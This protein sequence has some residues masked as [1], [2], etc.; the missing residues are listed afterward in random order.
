[1]RLFRCTVFFYCLLCCLYYVRGED[2]RPNVILVMADDMGWGDTGYNGHPRIKTPNLD[3]MAE[4]GFCLNRFYA[5]GPVC[6]PTR[7]SC[8]T[9][10]NHNRFGIS[11]ANKGHLKKEEICLAEVFKIH[12][13]QTG[14][15]GKWHLGTLFDN[16]SGKGA[17]RQPELNYMTPGM[18]GF[19]EW[20]STEFAVATYDPYKQSKLHEF[21]G[22]MRRG[23]V[24]NGKVIPQVLNGCDSKIIMDKALP[25]IETCVK[26]TK[27]FFVVV[28]FHAP[29]APIVG[30]PKY[31]KELYADCDKDK[32]SYYSVITA[33]DVQVGRLRKELRRLG[34]AN[35]TMVCF[36]S[37]NGPEGDGK[38]KGRYQGSA[39]VLRGRKRSLYE[40]GIRVPG[41]I[42]W[43]DRV[44]E[45]M[46]SD[47]PMVSS[48]YFVTCMDIL[49]YTVADDR[50]YDGISL[51]PLFDGK[52]CKRGSNI[53]FWFENGHQEALI[54]DHY[55]LVHN[56]STKRSRSDNS[57]VPLYE[58]ELYDVV[59]DPSETENIISSEPSV[60][61][62]MK[63]ELSLFIRSCKKSNAGEDY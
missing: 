24:H 32:Q 62:E 12:G 33:L 19:D 26:D 60:A 63:K 50:P 57:T 42:E 58:Y 18:S 11:Q 39:S 61:R 37:D 4:A 59:K 47:A 53:G 16:Y 51:M 9:G 34:V 21:K 44:E 52:K 29:H 45:G 36:S 20:F 17:K 23:Y 10:R 56:R 6:S 1:M 2:N 27:P 48:D 43:P 30:H 8:L 49:G 31:M 54:G 55:K 13:Y 7:G 3:S 35:N 5:A 46:V 14:H 38:M 22:D 40:G 41:I 25:F 28:W 15:F